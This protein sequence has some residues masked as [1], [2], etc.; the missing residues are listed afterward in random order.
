[1]K[2]LASL[3]RHIGGI[4]VLAL[5]MSAAQATTINLSGA[6][7]G[8][9][10]T[11]PTG[12]DNGPSLY[13]ALGYEFRATGNDGHFHENF[14]GPGLFYMHTNFFNTTSNSWVFSA[15]SN[16]LFDVSSFTL[17]SGN[18]N[19]VTNLGTS[20]STSVGINNVNLFG[21]NSL[22]FTLQTGGGS[23][24]MDT[25]VVNASAVPEPT[26]VALLGL[27]LLG[28]AASRRKSAKSKNT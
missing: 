25:F 28:V 20:G 2:T 13:T 26:T 9:V 3:A 6:P 5:S 14:M 23:G 24:D 22:T 17:Q 21:I 4:V 7:E 18:L 10:F 12:S 8:G 15:T 16:S 1:M 27:G 11:N 19:W